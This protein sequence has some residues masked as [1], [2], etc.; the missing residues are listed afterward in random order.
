MLQ[1][2]ELGYDDIS[3]GDIF[4]FERDIDDDLVARF[5]E[6]S[7]DESPLHVD[8]A[9]ASGTE[10]GGRIVHGMLL[11][12]FFSTLVGMLVPG[13]RAL[14]ISHEARFKNPVRSGERVIVEGVVTGKYSALRVIELKSLVKN[15]DGKIFVEGLLKVK[16]RDE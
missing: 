15:A 6:L 16:V 1:L 2:N 13:R 5:A 12:S 10:F 3:E 14:L 9:Y 7:G 8:E 4:S 11:S